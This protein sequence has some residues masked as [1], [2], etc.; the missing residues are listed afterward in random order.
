MPE[1]SHLNFPDKGLIDSSIIDN[2]WEYFLEVWNDEVRLVV[3]GG[4]HSC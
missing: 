4:I 2:G 3:D 1:W